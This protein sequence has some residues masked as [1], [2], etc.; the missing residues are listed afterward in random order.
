MNTGRNTHDKH[1]GRPGPA[2]QETLGR[3]A[4]HHRFVPD[5]AIDTSSQQN[6]H[7][8]VHDAV[9]DGNDPKPAV[10]KDLGTVFPVLDQIPIVQPNKATN[11]TAPT[12]WGTNVRSDAV[13]GDRSQL[14]VWAKEAQPSRLRQP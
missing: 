9:A 5:A 8:T 12:G 11:T 1:G 2:G 7:R 3:K 6:I 4:Q 14:I 10:G 13:T